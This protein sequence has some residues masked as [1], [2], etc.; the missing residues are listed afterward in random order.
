MKIFKHRINTITDLALTSKE[1]GVELDIRT[2]GK[3][4][5]L[6]HDP[7]E[8]GDLFEM[9]LQEYN[10]SGIILNTKE[11]GLELRLID[12]MK[13]YS[14]D[15]YFFLDL[16]LPF[17]IKTIKKGCKKVAVRYS[18]YE[19]IEYVKKFE[20]FAEWVWVDCFNKNIL[21]EE[22][23]DYLKM[24]F[25]IC[26]VS[27]ELQSHPIEWIEEFKFAYKSFDID[28]VCTKQP[29]LWKY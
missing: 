27:P 17:L 22:V 16:S 12:L 19:P 15:D 24:H 5:I 20:G 23:L 3:D 28:A 26:L 21:S 10:H 1:L 8:I 25:K 18:E 4:L 6:H 13:K 14:I 2:N 29:S 11:E 9:Y 7:F